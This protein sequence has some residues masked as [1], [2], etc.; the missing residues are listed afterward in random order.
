MKGQKS[1]IFIFV[2]RSLP[3][4][5]RVR[6]VLPGP[7]VSATP[8]RRTSLWEPLP[9]RG[10]VGNQ[11]SV[12]NARRAPDDFASDALALGWR[13]RRA[14]P[15]KMGARSRAFSSRTDSAD[16]DVGW[17]EDEIGMPAGRPKP[18]F[19]ALYNDTEESRKQAIILRLSNMINSFRHRG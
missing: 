5:H 17:E 14:V 10:S 4:V 13:R 12:A 9:R 6:R 15:S 1:S 18:Q 11:Y 7:S 16:L 8:T 2:Q 19:P 3:A